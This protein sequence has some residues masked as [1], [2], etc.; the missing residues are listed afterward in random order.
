MSARINPSWRTGDKLR[1]QHYS[2]I[3]LYDVGDGEHA[4]I[5]IADRVHRIRTAELTH[6]HLTAQDRRC[7]YSTRVYHLISPQISRNAGEYRPSD[8][9][10]ATRSRNASLLRILR[11]YFDSNH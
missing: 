11:P 9:I 7:G 10:E 4:N 8:G 2:G 1:W 6:H 5:V 3:F